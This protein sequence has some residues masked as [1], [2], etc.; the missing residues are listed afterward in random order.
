MNTIDIFKEYSKIEHCSGN[1][2]KMLEYLINKAKEY[3]YEY[4]TDKTGNLYIFKKKSKVCFQAHYDMVC[5]GSA[6][7]LDLYEEDNCIKAHNSSLGAD[8]GIGVAIILGLMEQGKNI[9]GLFTNDEEIGLI[10]AN[11]LNIDIKEN[12]MINL[13]S[14]EEDGVFI[15]CAGGTNFKVEIPLEMNYVESKIDLDYYKIEISGLPGGHSGLEINS[16]IDNAI[17]EIFKVINTCA[18]ELVSVSAGEKINSIPKYAKL[19]V[20]ITKGDS[21]KIY[22]NKV[23]V[24][25]LDIK[26][27][28]IL[29]NTQSIIS[30]INDF[31]N[32][33]L[34]FN[35]ELKVPHT[36]IN[37]ALMDT[38]DKK[39]TLE[40]SGRSMSTEN[41]KDLRENTE[42]Y[43]TKRGFFV[44]SNDNYPAWKPEITDFSNLVLEES[45][46]VFPKSEFKAMHA[47][48]ECAVIKAKQNHLSIV[49]IGPN[50][51]S[52]HTDKERV[53]IES[54]YKITKLIDNIL[55][56][57]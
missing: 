35:P 45:K 47:G 34:E 37:L 19:I 32:G 21:L 27:Q 30:M 56:Q 44:S 7:I 52:P 22:H 28:K 12:L 2:K 5:I 18:I 6:P 11:N 54:I 17:K 4:E 38:D 53:E 29:K 42:R 46:K 8:N 1:T 55:K 57:L 26:N 20:G 51:Y 50:I 13:D 15:G 31:E 41:L 24:T 49:S 36:S 39:I 25:K 33:M 48:L 40:L 9:S 14:E 23:T 10:G 43:F 3:K 16:N